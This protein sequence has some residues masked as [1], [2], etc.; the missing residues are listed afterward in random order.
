MEQIASATNWWVIKGSLWVEIRDDTK[1]LF[2]PPHDLNTSQAVTAWSRQHG[3][4]LAQ[5]SL[6]SARCKGRTGESMTITI[7]Q[8]C[9]WMSR[10]WSCMWSPLQLCKS[11]GWHWV[12]VIRYSL[13]PWAEQSW[14]WAARRRPFS[15]PLQLLRIL[16]GVSERCCST[17]IALLPWGKWSGEKAPLCLQEVTGIHRGSLAKWQ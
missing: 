11:S 14:R 7:S 13:F 16:H 17:G 1:N 15:L 8:P 4:L 12:G 9:S 3:Q 6:H 10:V 5:R 2:L